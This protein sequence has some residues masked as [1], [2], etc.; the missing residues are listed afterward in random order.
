MRVLFRV[1][2]ALGLAGLAPA[3]GAEELRRFVLKGSLLTPGETIADGA[4][5]VEDGRIACAGRVCALP[6]GYAVI[7]TSGV[8]LPGLVD[9]HNHADW[10]VHS[11][12]S[13]VPARA[14]YENRY[15][16][17]SK[18]EQSYQDLKDAHYALADSTGDPSGVGFRELM[19]LRG[20]VQ[21]LMGGVTT[22]QGG[23]RGAGKALARSTEQ[24]GRFRTPS[25]CST[26]FPLCDLDPARA[27]S[28]ECP[29]GPSQY[30]RDC[31]FGAASPSARLV[32]H[33]AEGTD[34][35]SAAE[36]QALADLFPAGLP[37]DRLTVI[38]GL[39]LS[40]AAWA[41]LAQRRGYLVWSPSSNVKLY[42]RSL[43]PADL[44]SGLRV[45]L[46]P[47]WALSGSKTQLQEIRYAAGLPAGTVPV[48]SGSTLER[49]LALMATERSAEAVGLGGVVGRLAKDYRADVLVL[50]PAPE[51]ASP[52]PYKSLAAARESDVA[53]VLVDGV[54]LYG[55]GDLVARF[56]PPPAS[57]A[58]VS[59]CGVEKRLCIVAARSGDG[60]R[61]AVALADAESA[62]RSRVPDLPDA[63]ECR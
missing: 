12:A 59:P 41:D 63:W 6:E 21:A 27:G 44:P 11:T 58:A 7:E 20:D 9:P 34:A 26:V 37:D 38:H 55:D 52:D 3:A 16:W 35:A 19:Y 57:C 2:V 1:V 43:R 22:I 54:V 23:Y 33:L 15:Q 17:Q 61:H 53:L 56:S 40:S 31:F 30:H 36:Y 25:A 46:G 18:V 48:P 28:K 60:A 51:R 29:R 32:V 24:D 14:V 4:L 13:W 10:N 45:A 8:I 39:G 49:E 50:R 42:G 5:V 62:L 47:D